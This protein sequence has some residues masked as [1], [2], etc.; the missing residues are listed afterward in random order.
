MHNSENAVVYWGWAVAGVAYALLSLRLIGQQYLGTAVNRI[1]VMMLAATLFTVMWS[2]GSLLALTEAPAWWLGAQAADIL[3]YLCWAVFV[4]LFFKTNAGQANGGWYRWWPGL[5]VVGLFGA[6][7]A[8]VMVY[9]LAG[10]KGQ[11]F[12]MV[13]FAIIGLVLLEQLLRNLPEDSLWSAKP[14]CLGLAG[15]F[16]FDLYVFS[17]GVLFQ[18]IDPEALS[19]RPF[20]HAL[21]VPLLWLATTR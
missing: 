2:V 12:L 13:L 15:I 21:M 19:V 4:A 8:L 10:A 18:G 14:L 3:R 6:P 17:Q 16:L 11:A 5:V 20:V 1:A 7:A 9:L